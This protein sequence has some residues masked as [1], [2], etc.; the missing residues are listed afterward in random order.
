MGEGGLR[1]DKKGLWII[2]LDLKDYDSKLDVT[3]KVLLGKK[4]V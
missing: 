3:R 2:P 1:K 4:C